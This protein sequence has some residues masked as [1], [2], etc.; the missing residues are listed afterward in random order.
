MTVEELRK[1][2]HEMQNRKSLEKRFHKQQDERRKAKIVKRKQISKKDAETIKTLKE[3]LK[4][5]RFKFYGEH[6]AGE[7]S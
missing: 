3:R 5:T 6:L 2:L 4:K 1:K 7:K